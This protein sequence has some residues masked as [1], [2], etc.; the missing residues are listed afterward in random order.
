MCLL[1]RTTSRA[2]RGI[3]PG[4]TQRSPTIIAARGVELRAMVCEREQ[5]SSEKRFETGPG[6]VELRLSLF[7]PGLC[8]QYVGKTPPNLR[9][10]ARERRHQEYFRIGRAAL[11]RIDLRQMHSR[12]RIGRQVSDCASI[13]ERGSTRVWYGHELGP[14]HAELKANPRQREGRNVAIRT[15]GL[16]GGGVRRGETVEISEHGAERH[17]ILETTARRGYSVSHREHR[18]EVHATGLIDAQRATSDL[19]TRCAQRRRTSEVVSRLGK[20]MRG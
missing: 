5:V 8:P 6:D 15:K 12:L 13:P 18:I 4:K 2:I 17:Q 19:L 11:A 7:E 9:I 3:R 10:A 16:A 14:Q 1:D 20:A